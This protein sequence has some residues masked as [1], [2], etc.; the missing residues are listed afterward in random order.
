[1]LL[2]LLCNLSLTIDVVPAPG[3]FCLEHFNSTET[4]RCVG[5]AVCDYDQRCSEST[6]GVVYYLKAANCSFIKV[7]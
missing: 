7:A 5:W 1:M 4:Q 3:T 2:L 6:V